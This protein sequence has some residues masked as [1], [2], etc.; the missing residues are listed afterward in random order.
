M[1]RELADFFFAVDHDISFFSKQHL[2]LP[3][4]PE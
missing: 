3:V 1:P 4:N 2:L